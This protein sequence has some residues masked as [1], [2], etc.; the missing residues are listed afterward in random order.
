[1]SLHGFG[2]HAQSDSLSAK[3][4]GTR[5]VVVENHYGVAGI[6]KIDGHD[7]ADAAGPGNKNILKWHLRHGFIITQEPKT[8]Q[9]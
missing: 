4:G 1:M 3:L 7:R 8:A 9:I 6:F 5:I 2:I